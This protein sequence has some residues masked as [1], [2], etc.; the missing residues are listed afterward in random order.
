MDSGWEWYTQAFWVAIT[1]G[2]PRMKCEVRVRQ[3]GKLICN[4]VSAK[5]QTS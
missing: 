2:K 5:A 3:M 1:E 4:M